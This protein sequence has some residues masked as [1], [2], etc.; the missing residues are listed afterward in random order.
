MISVF[1]VSFLENVLAFIAKNLRFT[2]PD[3]GEN[4]VPATAPAARLPIIHMVLN[5]VVMIL[6]SYLDLPLEVFRNHSYLF[7]FQVLQTLLTSQ[8]VLL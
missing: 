4:N 5:E 8:E 1:L 3:L 2:L 6:L 7:L